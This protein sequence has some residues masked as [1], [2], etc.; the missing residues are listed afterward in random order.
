MHVKTR[1]GIRSFVQK[2]EPDKT[3]LDLKHCC[4]GKK[5]ASMHTWIVVRSVGQVSTFE[6]TSSY[7][8][9]IFFEELIQVQGKETLFQFFLIINE[10]IRIIEILMIL[11][12]FYI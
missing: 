2:R 5:H 1:T 6:H 8:Y 4:Q 3:A 11:M 9:Q 10:M 7:W 12:I